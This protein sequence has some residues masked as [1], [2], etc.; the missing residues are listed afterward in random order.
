[1]NQASEGLQG[2]ASPEE[3]QRAADE[4]SRQLQEARDQV[5][6]EQLAGMQQTFQN[7][8]EIGEQMTQEQQRIEQALQDAALR[9]TRDRDSGKDPNSTGLTMAESMALAE[10]GRELAQQL[11]QLQQQMTAAQQNYSDQV[12][13][14]AANE[15]ERAA[16]EVTER[17]L[18][19]AVSE[20]ATYVEVG[21]N[22]YITSQ[23][24]AVT[25]AMRDLEERLARANELVE[26]A[27][28]PGD[29]DLDRARRQAEDLRAQLQQLAQNGQPGQ[30][31]GQQQDPNGSPSDQPGQQQGQ[32]G[33]QGLQ[34]QGGQQQ[35]GQ[36]GGFGD[37]FGFGPRN[38]GGA[39]D[40]R[41]DFFDGP[42]TLPDT[43]YDNIGDLTQIAR[44]AI[45]DLDLSPEEMEELY[46]LIRQLEGQ[47][48]NR[49]ESIL[50]QEYGEM[51]A[52]VE[53]LEA[54]LKLDED[55]RGGNVRTATSDEVPE[56]YQE[57]VAEYF[58]RLSREE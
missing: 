1:M 15:L 58:R 3:M 57:S 4:A 30:G 23:Q 20:T 8:A 38:L 11:Q 43:F 10:Q 34:G 31:Q 35:G 6:A 17:Q 39:W 41:D 49:N 25:S 53:Q 50:A 40:G 19:A 54:G 13:D 21:Y 12:P 47:Q 45:N 37:R 36:G 46:N 24:S 42:I 28:G 27:S 48:V 16:N 26:Q 33:Q 18:E 55:S 56:E 32:Q 9:A 5:A 44:S 7:M 22:L 2:N 52:L 51:L 14:A 29:S